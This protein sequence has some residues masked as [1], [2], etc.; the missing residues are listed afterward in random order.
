MANNNII[1]KHGKTF[2]W[3]SKFLDKNLLIPIYSIYEM[4]R[5]IDDIVDNHESNFAILELEKIKQNLSAQE[6]KKD[7]HACRQLMKRDYPVSNI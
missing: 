3:A 7:S 5:E 6:L 2:Y 4:C 1:R